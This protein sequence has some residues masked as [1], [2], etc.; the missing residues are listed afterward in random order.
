MRF[1]AV[2]ALAL[3]LAACAGPRWEK[4]NVTPEQ[5]KSDYSECNA[6]AN[7]ANAR[8]AAIDQDI[9][10]SRGHDW[11]NSGTLDTHKDVFEAESQHRTADVLRSCMLSKGYAPA[12]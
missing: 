2:S 3:V 9:L 4:S 11:A 5:A 7:E 8:D 12:K 6:L 10:A 1:V